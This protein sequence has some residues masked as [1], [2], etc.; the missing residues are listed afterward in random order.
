MSNDEQLRATQA[1]FL[2]MVTHELRSPINAINGY[3]DLALAGVG[4]ELNEQQREFVRRA[5]SS[6]E[7]LFALI[8]DL[9]LI[10]RADAGQLRLNR[11]IVK[12]QDIVVD[13]M[14][15]VEVTAADNHIAITSDVSKHLPPLYADEVRLQQL[16]RNLLSNALRFTPAGGQVLISASVEPDNRR[17]SGS[18]D[19]QRQVVHLRVRDS[20]CGIAPEFHERIFERFFQAPD[21]GS[22]G[23][24]GLGLTSARLI[25]EL[26]DGYL[27]LESEAGKGSTF[28]CFLPCLSA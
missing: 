12:L 9:L 6:S 18:S 21:T 4:G 25:V 16:M 28:S 3:L 8:E 17:L 19:E 22:T 20:G 15:E 27:T 14:E 26:H 13:A 5:R 23:G 2:S 11:G 24:Q 7:E 1:K 10:A